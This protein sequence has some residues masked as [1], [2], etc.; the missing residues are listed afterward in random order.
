MNTALYQDL[1][2]LRNQ[3]C[4]SLFLTGLIEVYLRCI[5]F[6]RR[7]VDGTR[8]SGELTKSATSCRSTYQLVVIAR[9]FAFRVPERNHPELAVAVVGDGGDDDGMTT[10]EG[11]DDLTLP[12]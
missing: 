7:G 6:T 12:L 2:F 4:V 3:S 11:R 8:N 10:E 9:V 1:P 5:H